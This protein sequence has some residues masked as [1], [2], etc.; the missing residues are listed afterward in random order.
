M[1]RTFTFTDRE[2]TL[3]LCGLT[4]EIECILNSIEFYSRYDSDYC[5]SLLESHRRDL[6]VLRSLYER[7]L[8]NSSFDERFGKG[9]ESDD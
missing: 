4:C 2:F 8:P 6:S 1:E 5:R 7:F 3:L 9:G